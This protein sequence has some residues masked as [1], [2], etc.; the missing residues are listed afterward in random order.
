MHDN[1]MY[2]LHIDEI[3]M[4]GQGKVEQSHSPNHHLYSA[5]A[6]VKFIAKFSWMNVDLARAQI[7]L[8]CDCWVGDT[9]T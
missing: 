6:E 3:L 5:P 2:L 8:H 4:A 7:T 9:C 1:I